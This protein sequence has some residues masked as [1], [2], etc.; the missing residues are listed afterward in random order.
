[1]TMQEIVNANVNAGHYFFSADT[2]RFFKSRYCGEPFT[3]AKGT[4]FVTSERGPNEIRSYTVRFTVD[5][6]DIETVGE[7]ETLQ[8]ALNA[9]KWAAKGN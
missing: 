1:M 8:G 2:I 7:F 5:G 6:S 9:A 4:F 3:C